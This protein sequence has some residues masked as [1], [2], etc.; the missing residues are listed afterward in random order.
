MPSTTYLMVRSAEGAS[1]TTHGADAAFF[2]RASANFLTASQAGAAHSWRSPEA[3][4]GPE[5]TDKATIGR[6]AWLAARWRPRRIRC[7]WSVLRCPFAMRRFARREVEVRLTLQ[8][9]RSFSKASGSPRIGGL[10]ATTGTP[11]LPSTCRR[12]IGAAPVLGR[13][14]APTRGPIGPSNAFAAPPL[15]SAPPPPRCAS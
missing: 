8:T 4:G 15:R 9:V 13:R 7:D 3:T 6:P 1:R 11:L 14:I 2:L 10:A 12:A 5:A